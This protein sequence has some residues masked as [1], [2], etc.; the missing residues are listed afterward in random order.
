MNPAQ[1]EWR[2]FMCVVRPL[3][4]SLQEGLQWR[5]GQYL[6]NGELIANSAIVHPNF[7]TARISDSEQKRIGLG[8]LLGKLQQHMPLPL[9]YSV[10]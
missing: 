6:T 9:A 7:K 10:R 1:R 5:C 3:V 4:S 8:F 2:Q